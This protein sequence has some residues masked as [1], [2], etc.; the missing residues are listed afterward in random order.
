MSISLGNFEEN[1]KRAVQVFWQTRDAATLKQ[2]ESGR[3]DQGNRSAV[4][5]G[6][7]MDGFVQ[8][9]T[10]VVLANGLSTENILL[11]RRVLTLPGFFRPTKS[12]DMLIVNK[13]HLIAAL[14]FKSQVGSF[15]NNFNNRTE[16]AVGTGLDLA[17]AYREGAFGDQAKPF[18]GWMMLL[19]DCTESRRPVTDRS[20]HFPIFE[21]FRGASYADRYHLLCKKLMQEELYDSAAFMLASRQQATDGLYSEIDNMTS[22]KTFASQ[23]A[24][25]IAVESL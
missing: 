6:K 22:L 17:T 7:N 13:G 9:I 8:L 19:E 2:Q 25:R 16:E 18:V 12:W 15:G 14:E 3:A 11:S 4:T 20:P 5:A 24:G 21:E 1:A 23:L 10:D